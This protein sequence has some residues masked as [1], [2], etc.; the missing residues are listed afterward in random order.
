MFNAVLT[1]L[2]NNYVC[3][4]MLLGNMSH[5]SSINGQYF[6][7]GSLDAVRRSIQNNFISQVANYPVINK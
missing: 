7:L 2:S 6:L 1:L 5:I 3:A 4:A